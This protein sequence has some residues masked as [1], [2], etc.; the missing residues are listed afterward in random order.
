MEKPHF[1][2]LPKLSYGYKDLEPYISQSS[3][4]S[5]TKS[6]IRPM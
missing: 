2:S 4:K 6:T 1:Y 3:F 5:I